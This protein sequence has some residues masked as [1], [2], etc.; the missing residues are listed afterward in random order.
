MAFS[1]E[2]L[3]PFVRDEMF[4]TDLFYRLNIITIV[5]GSG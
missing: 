5:L 2:P 1:A 3:W 4:R